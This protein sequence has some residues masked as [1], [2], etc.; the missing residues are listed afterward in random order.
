MRSLALRSESIKQ[1]IEKLKNLDKA[2]S[3]HTRDI[4]EA[5]RKDF[6][7]PESETF[8]TEIYPAIKELEHTLEYIKNWSQ[9]ISVG[10][11]LALTGSRSYILPEPKGLVLLI[12]PWNYPFQLIIAPLVSAIAAGNTVAIKPSEYTP[13]INAVIKNIVAQVFRPDEVSV[14][15]GDSQMTQELLKFPFDHIFFTG[16][17]AVGKIVMKA[18]AEHLASVTLELGGKSPCV[19]D[20]S[21]NV[22]LAATKIAWGKFINGGQT[23]IAPDYIFVQE[24]VAEKFIFDFKDQIKKLYPT[25]SVSTDLATMVSQKHFDRLSGLIDKAKNYGDLLI[26]G[27]FSLPE[28]MG[29]EPTVFKLKDLQSPLMDEELFGPIAPIVVYKDLQEVIDYINS[30]DKPLAAYLF[31]ENSKNIDKFETETSSGGLV[32]NDCLIHLLNPD[33]PFGGVNASGIGRY[34]GHFGFKEFSH[35]KPVL[36]Q[37]FLGR[38]LILLFPPYKGWKLKI[39]TLMTKYK[40]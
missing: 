22:T 18:A 27:S 6:N 30:K 29:I 10:S 15:E 35:E 9:P 13:N 39:A 38:L 37:G 14:F 16:S 24:K 12:G 17:T 26:C 21:A 7:K 2:I 4:T 33:L 11:P 8:M 36:R 20:E 3:L 23:C 25:D 31:S 28:K 5:L 32:I 1:R 34:H 19:V 40:L